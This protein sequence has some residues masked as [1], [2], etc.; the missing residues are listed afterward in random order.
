ME[1]QINVFLDSN[2]SE[3]GDAKRFEFQCNPPIQVGNDEICDVYVANFSCLNN[4][5][6]ID[7]SNNVFSVSHGSAQKNLVISSGYFSGADISSKLNKLFSAE[8]LHLSCMWLESQLKFTIQSTHADSL[9]YRVYETN[10]SNLMK[11]EGRIYTHDEIATS[12][13]Q[14]DLNEGSH[15]ILFSIPEITTNS[16]V[17]NSSVPR[18]TLCKIPLTASYGNYILY[19]P[20]TLVSKHLVKEKVIN[21]F[22]I[23][24]HL[25]NYTEHF[26]SRFHAQLVFTIKKKPLNQQAMNALENA[27]RNNLPSRP[28]S[29]QPFGNPCHFKI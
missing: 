24:L 13:V 5:W 7:D 21:N 16:R 28:A 3:S 22:T 6:N 14:P 12:Y 4:I 17:S 26:P 19:Q 9:T 20:Q 1:E 25:D 18:S 8:N 2:N 15:S 23:K 11:L 10:L 29:E 27:I